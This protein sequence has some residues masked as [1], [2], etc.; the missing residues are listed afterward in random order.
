M[1]WEPELERP[2]ERKIRPGRKNWHLEGPST[3]SKLDKSV[4]VWSKNPTASQVG[5]WMPGRNDSADGK[6]KEVEVVPA[7]AR[8]HSGAIIPGDPAPAPAHVCRISQD[9]LPRPSFRVIQPTRTPL[10]KRP[11]TVQL[12]AKSRTV[13]VSC[14]IMGTMRG[15]RGMATLR[16]NF[17]VNC[18]RPESIADGNRR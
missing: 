11:D 18:E 3:W 1:A 15:G 12:H 7:R 2:L 10:H 8:R 5:E 6:G 4:K 17:E 16:A 9:H 14:R 13:R